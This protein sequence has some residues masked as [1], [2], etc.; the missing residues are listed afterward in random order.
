MGLG[1]GIY[2]WG[3]RE[4]EGG[5]RAYVGED[6]WGG[7]ER[8]RGNGPCWFLITRRYGIKR[9]HDADKS[10][11]RVHNFPQVAWGDEGNTV[12]E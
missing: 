9:E 6:G 5:V 2:R 8:R 4:R 1:L 10:K 12:W 3:L 7:E 11:A